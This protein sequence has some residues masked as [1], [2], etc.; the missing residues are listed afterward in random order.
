[1]TRIA[2]VD[3][4]V[5]GPL[6]DPDFANTVPSMAAFIDDASQE[7]HAMEVALS[8][9]MGHV[10]TQSL[11]RPIMQRIVSFFRRDGNAKSLVVSGNQGDGPPE[12]VDFINDRLIF[13]G[14]V[15]YSG[16]QLDRARCRQLLA[17]AIET[18]RSYLTS[19]Q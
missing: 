3:V 6:N 18:Q 7:W 4:K 9:S 11:D 10:K 19:R 8:L 2:K 13:S 15:D 5:R 14:R 1:M 17:E 12:F 16:K